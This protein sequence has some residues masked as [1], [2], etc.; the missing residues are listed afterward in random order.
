MLRHVIAKRR[1]DLLASSG[2][3]VGTVSLA[4]GRPVGEQGSYRCF[5]S[6][7]GVRWGGVRSAAGTD[8]VQALLLAMVRAATHLYNSDEFKNGL[9]M[10]NGGRNLDLPLLDLD[11]ASVVPDPMLS[12]T[13]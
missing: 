2:E 11:D 9:I 6:I 3:R 4:F 10:L 7:D 12:I 8:A 5:F 13:V 1:Y